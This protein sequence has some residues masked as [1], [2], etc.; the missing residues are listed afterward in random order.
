[1]YLSYEEYTE[2][3]GTLEETAFTDLEFDAES[4]VNW[5]TF[6]RLK[7]TEWSSALESEELKRCMYQLIRLK[8]L[9]NEMLASSSGGGAGWGVGW[10]KEAGITQ[11]TNDGV[12]VSYNTMSSGELMAYFNGSK[13]KDDLIRQYLGSIV[14][15]LGRKI[16]YRG[17]YP[18]E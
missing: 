17:I 13:T 1:M 16:L 4:I 12:S 18:G 6:N 14:N 7:R 10:K 3:G 8:Q 9:E 11:E 15:D 2:Y 5:Y